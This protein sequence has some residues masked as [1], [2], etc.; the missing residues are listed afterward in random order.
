MCK[1]GNSRNITRETFAQFSAR[2]KETMG[3][4]S[5]EIINNIIESMNNNMHWYGTVDWE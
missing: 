1:T 4:L 2:V 3:K 5:G